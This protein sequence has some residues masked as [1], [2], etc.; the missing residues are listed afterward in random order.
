M[1]RLRSQSLPSG[2]HKLPGEADAP[3]GQVPGVYSRT[4]LKSNFVLWGRLRGFLAS[5]EFLDS[6]LESGKD[7]EGCTVVE[8]QHPGPFLTKGSGYEARV[9]PGE[10]VPCG[11]H[12][13][14]PH[15]H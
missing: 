2:A 10:G 8:R 15:P 3:P 4:E 1:P 13:S 6:S 11:Q 5:V 7:R 14:P 9:K 12:H